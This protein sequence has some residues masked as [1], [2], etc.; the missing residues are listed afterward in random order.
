M[1]ISYQDKPLPEPYTIYIKDFDFKRYMEYANED[2][3]CELL[4]GELTIHSPASLEHELIFKLILNLLDLYLQRTKL[5]IVLGSRFTMKLSETWAP[6]PDIMYIS[7]KNEEKLKDTYM[8]GAANVVFEILSPATRKD[9]LK[10]KLPKYVECGVS[11]VWIIDPQ[12]HKVIIHWKD[13]NKEI[14]NG[15]AESKHINGFKLMIEWLWDARNLNIVEKL[16]DIC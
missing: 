2:I 12:E 5:G 6:E 15:W 11:E 9:D 16:G 7:Q 13:E 4:D 8:D 1:V 3:D 14:Q 10:K